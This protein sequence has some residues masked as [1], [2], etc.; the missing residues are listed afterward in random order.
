MCLDVS[1]AQ[2]SD[3]KE[4]QYRAKPFPNST[5]LFANSL[6]SFLTTEVQEADLEIKD[7]DGHSAGDSII[8]GEPPPGVQEGL[9]ENLLVLI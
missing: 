6:K 8:V 2:S 9:L 5:L 7:D 3:Q 4:A 1:A